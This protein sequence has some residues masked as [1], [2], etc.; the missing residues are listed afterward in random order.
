MSPRKRPTPDISPDV[1]DLLD[2]LTR[3]QLSRIPEGF[4]SLRPDTPPEQVLALLDQMNTER[5]ERAERARNDPRT[6]QVIEDYM[7]TLDATLARLKLPKK[8]A[9]KSGPRRLP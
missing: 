5:A 3:L 7:K 6:D 9:T 2:S 1:E 4:W 8:P